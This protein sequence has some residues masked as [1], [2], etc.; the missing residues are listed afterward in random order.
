MF[1][2]REEREAREDAETY[3][4]STL[5][6]SSILQLTTIC[7]FPRFPIDTM[8]LLYQSVAPNVFKVLLSSDEQLAYVAVLTSEEVYNELG[9]TFVRSHPGTP[10]HVAK[11]RRAL[12]CIKSWK[13]SE[14]KTL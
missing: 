1:D 13:A 11:Y 14:W 8:Y 12:D 4:F 3:G 9:A 2:N 6:S 5:Y 7:A 10:E